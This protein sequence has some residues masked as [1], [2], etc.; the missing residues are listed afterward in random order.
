MSKFNSRKA[1]ARSI[2]DYFGAGEGV[3]GGKG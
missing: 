3:T 1:S 2:W